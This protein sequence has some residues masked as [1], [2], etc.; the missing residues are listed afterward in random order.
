MVTYAKNISHSKRME[1]NYNLH[2]TIFYDK[3][4]AILGRIQYWILVQLQDGE[5]VSL[6]EDKY[7]ETVDQ[8]GSEYEALR[9]QFR[10]MD[11]DNRMRTKLWEGKLYI[12]LPGPADGNGFFA[13]DV[14]Q[15]ETPQEWFYSRFEGGFHGGSVSTRSEVSNKR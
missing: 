9:E 7:F 2:T 12:S 4:G 1:E 15:I 5:G 3:S 11:F 13:V 14:G 8:D 10:L 6:L